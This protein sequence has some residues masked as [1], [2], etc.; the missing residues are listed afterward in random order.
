[1]RITSTEEYG[2]RCVLHVARMADGQPVSAQAIARHEG[3]SVPYVQKLMRP[4]VDARILVALRG[5]KG[6]YR[7]GRRAD[8]VSLAQI[9]RALDGWPEP[10]A[11][12]ARH[13]GERDQCPH[14]Q[15]SCSIR[16]VW[17]QLSGFLATVF[18]SL[19]LDLL[20]GSGEHV[21]QALRAM[22]PV[23]SAVPPSFDCP[24]GP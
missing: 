2:L 23:R 19:T 4:L 8:K 21:E 24:L 13:T 17:E 12:C 22:L 14:V 16:P 1:M 9:F 11:I 15:T 10:D 3:L 20:A 7:L 18:E 6:G 5:S